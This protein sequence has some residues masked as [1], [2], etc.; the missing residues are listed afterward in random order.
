MVA[1]CC[2]VL[3]F[4]C[5]VVAV[6]CSVLQQNEQSS[7]GQDARCGTICVAVCCSLLQFVAVSCSVVRVLQYIAGCCAVLQCV[8]GK[9]DLSWGQNARSL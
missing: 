3:Q 1:M 6:C 2:N 5:S 4:V 8:A 9:R 7:G